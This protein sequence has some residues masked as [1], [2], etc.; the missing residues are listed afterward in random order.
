MRAKREKTP[1]TEL[2]GEGEGQR[3]AESELGRPR[4]RCPRCAWEHDWRP[5]WGCELCDAVFDTFVTRACCP[6]PTCGNTWRLTWCPSCHQ[7]S[8]HA[9][10]YVTERKLN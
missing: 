6:D 2:P 3:D 4:I 8:P 5:H 9:D 7:P 10:W 1:D